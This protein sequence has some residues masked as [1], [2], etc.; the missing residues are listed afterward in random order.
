MEKD[1]PVYSYKART[2]LAGSVVIIDRLTHEYPVGPV[3]FGWL[4]ISPEKIVEVLSRE[5]SSGW[6]WAA[7]AA[8]RESR[9]CSVPLV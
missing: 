7:C 3:E 1:S 5:T 8:A 9:S 6:S 2:M 4:E